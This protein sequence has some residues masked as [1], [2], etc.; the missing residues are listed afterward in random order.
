MNSQSRNPERVEIG[1]GIFAHAPLPHFS[2]PRQTSL[3]LPPERGP[4]PAPGPL[5]TTFQPRRRLASAE[6]PSQPRRYRAS[7]SALRSTLPP[8]A[9]RSQGAG[10][11]LEPARRLR[12][13]GPAQQLLPG[14]WP[15]LL[16]AVRQVVDDHPVHARTPFV[17]LDSFQRLLAVFPLA[18][19][20]HQ[21]LADGRA[22][23]LPASPP[24]MRSLRWRL[25]GLHPYP[26]PLRPAPTGSSAARRS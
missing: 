1:G 2:E 20:L 22:F 13:V 7:S 4:Q 23:C 21:L 18:D 16:Q 17:G 25:L 15:A 11:P 10:P 6:L 3:P 8:R 24:A 26:P 19:F 12:P 9:L 5:F 14:C